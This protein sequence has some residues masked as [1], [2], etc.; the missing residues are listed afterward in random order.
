MRSRQLFDPE[1]EPVHA[2]VDF[3]PDREAM[4]P[5]VLLQ[6]R[7]LLERMDHELQIVRGGRFEL[8]GEER[9]FE[10]DDRMSDSRSAQRERFVDTRDA[11]RIRV[12]K[13]PRGVNEAMAVGISFDGSD[14]ASGGSEAADGVRGGASESSACDSNWRSCVSR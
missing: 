4:S 6:H 2:G 3:Q 5:C 7:E 14:D 12:S 11:E 1:A 8:T 10:N 13:C 9:A